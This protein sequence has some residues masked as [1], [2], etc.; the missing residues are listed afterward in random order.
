M[1]KFGPLMP[2]TRNFRNK[3][4]HLRAGWRIAAYLLFLVPALLPTIVL[5]KLIGWFFPG[6]EKEGLTSPVNIIFVFCLSLTLILAA[7]GTLR[8]IDK[9]PYRLLG[10]SFSFTSL[11]EFLRGFAIGAANLTLVVLLLWA[12][13][14][15]QIGWHGVDAIVLKNMGV[16]GVFMLSGAMIE[17]IANRGYVLQ[18]LCEGTRTWIAVLVMSLVFS[19]VHLFNSH[20]TL[21]SMGFLL[22]HGVLYALAY[23]KTRS[24]WTAIGVHWSWNWMQGPVF[25]VN[26]SGSVMAHSLFTARPQG[27][28]ILSGGAFG[29][30]GS[31]LACALSLGFAAFVWRTKWLTPSAAMA[32][33]WDHYPRGFRLPPKSAKPEDR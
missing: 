10:L 31:L 8:W 29:V 1:K 17:E 16:L 22:I 6:L 28:E 30:E 13:G 7:Y 23:L 5:L 9:R 21:A 14:F 15:L 20:M 26:V 4:G 19:M 27:A 25:G 3:Y 18:A 12:L 2:N 24:L 32:A 11:P 33:L